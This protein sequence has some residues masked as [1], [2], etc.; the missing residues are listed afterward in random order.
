MD[1]LHACRGGLGV[2]HACRGQESAGG[3]RQCGVRD[4][5]GSEG[6]TPAGESKQIKQY[7]LPPHIRRWIAAFLLDRTQQ[8]KIGNNFSPSRHPKGAVPQGRLLGLNVF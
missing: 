1:F 6:V 7:D 2:Q 8:V 3:R 5:L 4:A